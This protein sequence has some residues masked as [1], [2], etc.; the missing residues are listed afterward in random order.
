MIRLYEPIKG[1]GANLDLDGNRLIVGA[2]VGGAG[3]DFGR[4]K[5][6]IYEYSGDPGFSGWTTKTTLVSSDAPNAY[7]FGTGVAISG[8]YAAGSASGD[9][10]TG[11]G[12]SVF[13]FE[14]D[15]SGVWNEVEK[16]TAPSGLPYEFFGAG[17]AMDGNRLVVGASNVTIG[18]VKSGAVYVYERNLAGNWLL[19]ATLSPSDGDTFDGFGSNVD[20]NGNKIIVGSRNDDD[21]GMN[22]GAAYI[23]EYSG[24]TWTETQKYTASDAAASDNFGTDVSISD[25]YAIAGA[26][27]DDDLGSASGS[28]YILQ[29][30]VVIPPVPIPRLILRIFPNPNF[31]RFLI[32]AAVIQDKG[33]QEGNGRNSREERG[34]KG[35]VVNFNEKSMTV[36]TSEI[37]ISQTALLT[38]SNSK[39]EVILEEKIKVPFLKPFDLTAYGPGIYF[40]HIKAGDLEETQRVLVKER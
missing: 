38:I 22:S 13:I 16:L 3:A 25:V 31:G 8:D 5:V 17:L 30:G 15:G 21:D 11:V 24:G 27:G 34:N 12:E 26:N 29:H 18:G 10:N 9:I 37:I 39:G 4:G 28:A 2:P 6:F 40:V 33:K 19:T 1:F 20:I 7:F 32:G 23:F 14:R 36:T 35:D